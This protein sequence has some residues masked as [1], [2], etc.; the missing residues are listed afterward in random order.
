MSGSKPSGYRLSLGLS[1]L[2]GVLALV[3]LDQVGPVPDSPV[4]DALPPAKPTAQRGAQ[5]IK[6]VPP[7][8][9][10]S[11]TRA[12]PLF[13]ASRRPPE[14]KSAAPSPAP[15][16]E[17]LTY[18]LVGVT[19]FDGRGV[20]LIRDRAAG[21]L[22]RV[23]AGQRL[24]PWRVT[25]IEPNRLRLRGSGVT[26]ELRLKDAKPGVTRTARRAVTEAAPTVSAVDDDDQGATEAAV[27]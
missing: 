5:D 9:A 20:A 11:E 14:P 4:L 26:R 2:A 12:R 13:R 1:G 10:L 23:A 24:G 3:I 25:G 17:P 22:L 21:R 27:K 8:E 19:L 6:S 15:S 16:L 7:L 18:D